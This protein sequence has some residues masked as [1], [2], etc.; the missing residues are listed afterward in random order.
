M[1]SDLE[2]LEQRLLKTKDPAR[3]KILSHFFKTGTGEYGEGDIFLGIVVGKSRSIAKEFSV[4]SLTD[5]QKL[6]NSPWH[7]FRLVALLI[8]IQKYNESDSKTKKEQI[9]K[10]YLKNLKNINNWDLVDLSCSYLL[11]SYLFDK[12]RKVLYKLAQAKSMWSRRIAMVTTYYFIKNNDLDDT[13]KLAEILLNNKEDLMHKAVG[14]MLREAG[15]RDK[16]RLEKFINKYIKIMPRT[17]LRYA[18]EKFPEEQR[19]RLLKIK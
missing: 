9:I 19:Q 16:V 15:K 11:G 3:A 7:E 14:W 8:L 10:F 18:I 2:I 4:L 5:I 12:D 6:L 17:T 1:K 13:F